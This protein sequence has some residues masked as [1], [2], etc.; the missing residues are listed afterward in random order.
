MTQIYATTANFLGQDYSLLVAD[1]RVSTCITIRNITGCVYGDKDS[2]EIRKIQRAGNI[3]YA[4]SGTVVPGS[5][6]NLAERL[7]NGTWEEALQAVQAHFESLSKST[8]ESFRVVAAGFNHAPRIISFEVSPEG[9]RFRKPKKIVYANEPSE[10]RKI[11]LKHYMSPRGT[12]FEEDALLDGKYRPKLDFA[13]DALRESI[14]ED[15]RKGYGIS[16]NVDIGLVSKSGVVEFDDYAAFPD[17]WIKEGKEGSE[18]LPFSK[19]A[20]NFIEQSKRRILGAPA[21]EDA[22]L[23]YRVDLSGL[24]WI[25]KESMTLSGYRKFFSRGWEEDAIKTELLLRGRGAPRELLSR[26]DLEKRL[27][28]LDM[29][30]E[31]IL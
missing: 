29:T 3:A 6:E 13:I 25:V 5:S 19:A 8:G 11:S 24:R 15:R 20:G 10:Y 21:I 7:K 26:G 12:N 18:T 17:S 1:R 4:F 22:N 30:T 31:P 27:R 9:T 2:D 14:L 28:F 23:F 16:S